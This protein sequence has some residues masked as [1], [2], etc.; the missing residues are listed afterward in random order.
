MSRE[1]YQVFSKSKIAD[2]ELKNRLVRSATCESGMTKDG[3]ITDK[4]SELY[5]NLAAGGAGMIITGHMA[6]MEK[7]KALPHQTLICDDKYIREISPI[8]D[9][10]HNTQNDCF[11]VAQ[12]SHA[13]RQVAHDNKTAECVGPSDVPSTVIQNNARVLDEDEIESIIDAFA[14]AIGRV[15]QA[16]FDAVQLHSAHGWLLS[17]FLSP[18]TNKRKDKYG[19]SVKNRVRILKAIIDKARAKVK[20]FPILI[21]INCDDNVENGINISNFPELAKEIENTGFDAIEISGAMWDCL[22]RSE[23]ELG[24]F[25]APIPEAHIKIGNDEKQSYYEKYTDD[26]DLN[27][28]VILLGGH[29]NIEFLEKIITKQKADF[30]SFSRPLI[31]E[32]D[33]PNRWLNGTGTEK[34]DCV[35][36]NSCLLTIKY[37]TLKCMMKKNSLTQKITKN[38]VPHLWKLLFK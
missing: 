7:G 4:M 8:A 3:K 28:P 26:L 30:F 16:G 6:V 22:S 25:P 18:Y 24:F 12:L 10:I 19:G 37:S 27:I 36:C 29:R 38:A 35:S 32:P 34:A 31:C 5:K 23:E 14:D 13:G 15:K 1:H 20:D 17:S 21:K 11:A 2:L 9:I 33:L